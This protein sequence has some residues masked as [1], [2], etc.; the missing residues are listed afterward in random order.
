MVAR[1]ALVLVTGQIR[2]LP[3]GD[4]LVG[5]TGGAVDAVRTPVTVT[6]AAG[7]TNV[8]DPLT[9]TGSAYLSLYGLSMAAAQWQVATAADF[10]TMPVNTG[11]VAGTATTRSVASGVLGFATQYFWRVRYRDSEGVYSPW[12]PATAF[13]TA[14]AAVSF[15]AT[16]AATPATF[17]DAFE[18]GFYAGMIWNELVQSA[19]STVIGTGSKVFAVPDMTAVPLV[20]S[21]QVLEVRSRANPANKMVGTV[22]DAGATALTLNITSVGGSGTFTDWSVMSQY[23]IIVAPKATETTLALKNVNDA[24]PSACGTLT[25]GWKATL[26]MVA[27]G[28]STVYPSAH[29][30]RNLTTGGKTDWYLGARDE[31]ELSWRNLKP[32]TDANYAAVDRQV[33]ATPNYSNL[34]SYGDVAATHGKN[35]NSSPPG[36]AYTA[37]SPAQI[38]ATGFVTAGSEAYE[39][40]TPSYWSASEYS[41]TAAWAQLWTSGNPGAQSASNKNGSK[42]IRAIRRSII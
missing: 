39:Y 40:G 3:A 20:Y 37:G 14:A 21:G 31:L 24:A 36:P 12:S 30:C 41:A 32:T 19:S 26:S 1:S 35:N 5:G 13:T 10:V 27:A 42:R 33:A 2:E 38:G 28:S 6:P 9:L 18:G 15:I 4:T 17:G 7:A 29:Y 22:T 23:R 34:G 8:T 25:E 16:P 11:D